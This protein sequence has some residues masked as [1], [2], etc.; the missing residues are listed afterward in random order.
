MYQISAEESPGLNYLTVSE[1]LPQEQVGEFLSGA[2][3]QLFGALGSAGI[4]PAGPPI[5]RYHVDEVAFHVTAGVPFSGELS[6]A[7]PMVVTA[8]G[9]TTI[10]TT[11]HQGS[12]DGLPAAFHAVIEWVRENG[13][14]ITADPWECYLDG[15]EVAQPRT[16]VCFPVEAV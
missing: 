3:Q 14:R 8:I 15:P 9:P 6:A 4:A 16:K 13:Y 7:A 11:I 5:A 1:S 2:Y 12:Y 10:A